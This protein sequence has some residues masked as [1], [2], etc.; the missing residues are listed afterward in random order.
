MNVIPVFLILDIFD[1]AVFAKSSV[2]VKGKAELTIHH[3]IKHHLSNIFRLYAAKS[4]MNSSIRVF[5]KEDID[6]ELISQSTQIKNLSSG[7]EIKSTLANTR[8]EKNLD[9]SIVFLF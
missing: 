4:Y 6:K 9:F 5:S 8:V 7:L 3:K 1:I 2:R